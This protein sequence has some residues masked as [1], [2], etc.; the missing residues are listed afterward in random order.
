MRACLVSVNLFSLLCAGDFPVTPADYGEI[1]KYG[2]PI[3]YLFVYGFML[4]GIL[5]W[6]D[7]GSLLLWRWRRNRGRSSTDGQP[8]SHIRQDVLDEAQSVTNSND[9]L[10]VLQVTKAFRRNTVVEDVS[11]GVSRNTIFALLGPNGAGK[12][13]TF[14]IIREWSVPVFARVSSTSNGRGQH[15]SKRW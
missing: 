15:H 4:F 11:F 6:V 10:R 14:N 12:T 7:S 5:I 2:G 8:D 9:S 1:T 13:T 3:A